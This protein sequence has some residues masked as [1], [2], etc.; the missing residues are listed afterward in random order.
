MDKSEAAKESLE[1]DEK[2]FGNIIKEEIDRLNAKT[3]RALWKKV[4]SLGETVADFNRLWNGLSD[5]MSDE[6]ESRNITGTNC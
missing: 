2:A 1:L 5:H 3:A 6:I 4:V